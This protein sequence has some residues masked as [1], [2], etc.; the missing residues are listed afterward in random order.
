M[1]LYYVKQ[2]GLYYA[3][4]DK[5]GTFI[6]TNSRNGVPAKTTRDAADKLVEELGTDGCEV[7]ERVL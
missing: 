7:E 5:D 6:F 1:T 4:K 3:G 2:F